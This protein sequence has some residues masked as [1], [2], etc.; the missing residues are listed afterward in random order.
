MYA[1]KAGGYGLIVPKGFGGTEE[2]ETAGIGSATD[3]I[4]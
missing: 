2:S 3:E 4:L 1:R